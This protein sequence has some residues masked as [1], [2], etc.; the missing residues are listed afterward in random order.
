[1]RDSTEFDRPEYSRT[2]KLAVLEGSFFTIAFIV[3]QGFIVTGLALEFNASEFM[4]AIIGVLPTLAQLTQLVSPMILKRFKDR[5]KSMLFSAMIGRI[6]LAFVP[7]TL[8]FGIKNQSLLLILLAL[9]SL[10]NSLVGTFWASIM[11]D[12]IDPEKTGK[13]YGKR[14]LLLSLTSILITP[15]Y[16]YILDTFDGKSGFTIVTTMASV[17]ALSSI[18]LLSKH[19]SPPARTF[20]SSRMFKEVFSNLKFRQY[21]KFSILWN[22]AITISG[23]FYSYHQLVNLKISYSYL[24]IMSIGASLTAM[25]MYVIWGKISDQIGHQSVAEFGILGATFLALMWTF[26]TPQTYSILMPVD[27]VVTGFVWSAINLCLFTMMMGMM[28]GLSVESYFAVQAF[29]NGL[30]A[31]AGSLLGGIIA[32]FL[33]GKNINI[34]GMDFYGIQLIF[35]VGSALRLAAFFTLKK[36][37]TSKTKSVPQLFFNVMS[38]FGRRM[39]VRPYEF[40]FL[41]MSSTK[42][43]EVEG[44]LSLDLPASLKDDEES[45][46]KT[47]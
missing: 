30:G 17:F 19:Y 7:V 39:A 8:A 21:L 6:P 20:G 35:F 11:R 28:K 43:K 22:F 1:M 14:N 12:V 24:S 46:G 23:P 45:R 44:P 18:F 40:P 31:L 38:T 13:Y 27:A 33:K 4:I 10:G 25:I 16:S 26:V 2:R 15:V 3:T 34:F 47:E 29:M 42:K 5:K 9:I 36:V 41:L 32:S 37:Q